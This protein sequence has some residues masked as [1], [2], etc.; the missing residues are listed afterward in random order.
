MFSSVGGVIAYISSGSASSPESCMSD[1]SNSSNSS[2]QSTSPSLPRPSLPS[3]AVGLV[4]DIAPPAKQ[5]HQRSHGAE[6]TGR[7]STSSKSS[8]TSKKNNYKF[9]STQAI[10]VKEINKYFLCTFTLPGKLIECLT[11][12]CRNQWNGAIVQGLW[13]CRLRVPLRCPCLRGLQGEN[14]LECCKAILLI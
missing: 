7:S 5:G 11:F 14:E 12:F 1:S 4:V 6:K 13:R 10:N 9:K 8:I 3:R 2:Y